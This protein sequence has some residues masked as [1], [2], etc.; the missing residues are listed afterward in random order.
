MLA[1]DYGIDVG[2]RFED[3]SIH[4]LPQDYADMLGWEELTNITAGAYQKIEDKKTVLIYG[5]NYGQ[6]AAITIIGNKYGLPDAISFSE[7]FQYWIPKKFDPDI[8]SLIYI[9]SK[10]GEDVKALFSRI[11]IVGSIT[12]RDAREYGTTVYLCQD[13]TESF[14]KFWED[15][16]K[17]R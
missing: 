13:P 12:N 6:A 14:N 4:S 9:N 5:E 8:K 11:T 1:T 16:L 3:G 10:P 2:R 17:K 15:R 7:S